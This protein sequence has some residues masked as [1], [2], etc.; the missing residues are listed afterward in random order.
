MTKKCPRCGY[1][2]S[3]TAEFCAKCGYALVGF[4]QTVVPR[5]PKPQQSQQPPTQQPKASPPPPPPPPPSPSSTT[6]PPPPPPPSSTTSAKT[7]SPPPPP[8]PPPPPSSTTSAKTSS[9]PP[10]P[11]SPSSTTPIPTPSQPST[12]STK[13][14]PVSSPTTGRAKQKSY[15]KF[16]A[17]GIVAAIVVVA[18][19]F[20]V[21]PMFN[22]GSSSPPPTVLLSSGEAAAIFGGQWNNPAISV[23]TYNNNLYTISGV[24]SAASNPIGSYTYLP[25]FFGSTTVTIFNGYQEVVINTLT[26][27]TYSNVEL[28][29][30]DIYASSSKTAGQMYSEATAQLASNGLTHIQTGTYPAHTG[31]T[32]TYSVYSTTKGE[33]LIAQGGNQV[34][35][36]IVLGGTGNTAF[37]VSNVLETLNFVQ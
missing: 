4:E 16:A 35:V 28:Q 20:F 29:I 17:I 6:T 27:P 18:V 1:E 37:S 11:P 3:D 21:L 8:P 9:P 19:V 36:I 30:I 22:S 7:S 26:S 23:I 5:V 24:G 13:T 32:Y 2:N 25:E 14:S 34:V 33:L 31:I 10:P 15:L 12:S